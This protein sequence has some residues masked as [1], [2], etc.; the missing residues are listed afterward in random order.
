[1]STITPASPI[2]QTNNMINDLLRQINDTTTTPGTTGV[3]SS[4]SIS[5]DQLTAL[6]QCL[7][8]QQEA[9][10]TMTN[11]NSTPASGVHPSSNLPT[12]SGISIPTT[13]IKNPE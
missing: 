12:S 9:I 3:S 5:T 4:I 8:Q 10:A 11:N 6:L 13:T 7:Q 1:M 2:P